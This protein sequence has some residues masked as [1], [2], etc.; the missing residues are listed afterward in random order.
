MS[1]NKS[2]KNRNWI[3]PLIVAAIILA[4]AALFL[5]LHR[6]QEP[7]PGGNPQT[8]VSDPIEIDPSAQNMVD[9]KTPEEVQTVTITGFTDNA[10]TQTGALEH[11]LTVTR[12]GAYSGKF[13]ED[14]SDREVTDVLSLIITNNSDRFLEYAQLSLT[15]GEQTAVFE[16]T[17]LPAGQSALVMEKTA[18]T[19]DAQ[20]A[21]GAPTIMT[22]TAPEKTFSL[23]PEV[24]SIMAADG[25]VNLQ[26]KTNMSIGGHIAIHYKNV[27]NGI[28]IGGLTYRKTIENGVAAGGVAQFIA[29]NY[30]VAGSE[31]V[32]IVYEP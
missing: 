22:Y 25:V 6:Q 24:F 28:Y 32:F 26:N 12:V 18:M 3:L 10:F 1:G 7:A 8:P 2:R 14:G 17:S 20:I 31:L 5:F 19:Y 30:T 27:E 16:L 9:P 13:V 29:D 11:G 4:A 21:Y 23:Y 15:A